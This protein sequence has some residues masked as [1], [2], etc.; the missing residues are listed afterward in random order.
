MC[1]LKA[2]PTN[3]MHVGDNDKTNKQQNH[4]IPKNTWC[5]PTYYEYSKVERLS[6]NI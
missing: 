4:T 6:V 5:L 1:K 2:G 3:N